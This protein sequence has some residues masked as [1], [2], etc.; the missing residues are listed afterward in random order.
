MNSR[1]T[2]AV[3]MYPRSDSVVDFPRKVE[4]SMLT[5]LTLAVATVLSLAGEAGA[6]GLPDDPRL[7]AA[8][9]RLQE[10]VDRAAAEGLPVEMIVGKVR[11]GLA[12]GVDPARIEAAAVRI[13]DN[14]RAAQ[15][16]LGDRRAPKL[17]RAVAEARMAG[18]ALA[19]VDPLVKG[20]RPQAQRAVEVVTDLS[21]RGYPAERAAAILA[22]V[23][24]R[25]AASL[26]RVPG[27]LESL[28]Q[29]YALTQAEAVDA[30]S[31][32]LASSE[33]LQAAAKRT[34]DEEQ[35]RGRGHGASG[36]SSDGSEGPG[37]SGLAPGHLRGR[38]P[39]AGPKKR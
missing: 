30:L 16:Y 34:A 1:A 35:R 11:E 38:P 33:S 25:D 27:T 5:T 31:R 15:T 10:M 17:V 21:L 28:R 23:M 36:K 6:V 3:A 7:G 22:T 14:L 8:R 29:E 39:T 4:R 19:A 26:D 13:T 20:D 32:G 37:K 12:K 9:P 2:R 24:A 18:V